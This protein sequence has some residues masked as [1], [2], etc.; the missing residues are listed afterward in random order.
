MFQLLD[1]EFAYYLANQDEL[2]RKFAG[3]AIVIRGRR[4]I[5]VYPDPLTALEKT[6]KSHPLGSFLIQKVELGSGAYT[7]IFYSRFASSRSNAAF[8]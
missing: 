3:K 4:L 2:V 7:H 8:E 1:K 5:G 6:K